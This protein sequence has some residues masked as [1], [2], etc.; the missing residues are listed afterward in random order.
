LLL[1]AKVGITGA[2]GEGSAEGGRIGRVGSGRRSLLERG[3][4]GR[5]GPLAHAAVAASI[6]AGLPAAALSDGRL[7]T[8]SRSGNL[9]IWQ[10][11]SAEAPADAPLQPPPAPLYARE[12]VAALQAL[13]VLCLAALRDGSERVVTGGRG[14]R[15]RLWNLASGE[16]ETIATGLPSA[17]VALAPMH[18]SSDVAAGCADGGSAKPVSKVASTASSPSKKEKSWFCAH[19]SR[20]RL[21]P[22]S[23][24]CG[25]GP[26][27]SG[28][29]KSI[30]GRGLWTIQASWE[31]SHRTRRAPPSL[32]CATRPGAWR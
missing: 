26:V 22:Q 1:S 21:P 4:V 8:V 23:P 32:G 25:S 24:G 17:I 20:A 10:K 7:V 16:C 31:P 18:G 6:A 5:T 3:V 28:A 15:L 29:S 2:D 11:L 13:R 30:G 27:P 9:V 12:E 19:L 14:G